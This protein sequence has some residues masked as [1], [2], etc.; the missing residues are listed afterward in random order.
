MT[1][2]VAADV[3][4]TI[5]T[6]RRLG[7]RNANRV[8]LAFGDSALTYPA[9][10]IPLTKAKLGCPNIVESLS[11]VSQGT[12]G[13]VFSYDQTNNKL[14]VTRTAATATHTH[15]LL[16]KNAA[17]ADGATTRVNAGANLLGA[18]TGGDLT[19]TGSGANGGVVAA[20]AFAAAA[21]A[22]ATSLAIAAQSIEVEVIG[23]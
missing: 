13:Y 12:S 10:G 15:D 19:V 14:V 18:N 7:S 21:L 17:V 1:A 8:R 2:F 9:G 6:K 20:A 5:L 3:T 16:L 11:V 4:Y 23:W 22:E